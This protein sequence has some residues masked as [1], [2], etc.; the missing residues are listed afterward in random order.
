MVAIT[1]QA[2]YRILTKGICMRRRCSRF[3]TKTTWGIRLLSTTVSCGHGNQT[4]SQQNLLSRRC[5]TSTPSSKTESNVGEEQ[6]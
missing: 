6:E 5:G 4:L 1:A 2:L 3:A